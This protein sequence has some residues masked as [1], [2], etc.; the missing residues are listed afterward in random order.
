MPGVC[1]I[2]EI[3]YNKIKLI[4]LSYLNRCQILRIDEYLRANLTNKREVITIKDRVWTEYRIN[5]DFVRPAKEEYKELKKFSSA[6]ICDCFYKRQ[7]LPYDIKPLYPE[8][9]KIVGP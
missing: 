4:Y 6:N 9:R 3:I 2:L 7:A 5:N 1:L 8:C